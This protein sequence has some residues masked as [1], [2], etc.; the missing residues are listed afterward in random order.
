MTASE[1]IVPAPG[2]IP[3][4]DE[5]DP[6]RYVMNMDWVWSRKHNR[7]L[8]KRATVRATVTAP[9]MG[10]LRNTFYEWAAHLRDPG[11]DAVYVS[12]GWFCQLERSDSAG[13]ALLF[14]SRGQDVAE[15]LDFGIQWFSGAVLGAIPSAEVSWQELPLD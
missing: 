6:R 10:K 2:I 7:E 1:E 12:G 14:G 15:S 11:D 9:D 5:S 13:L 4:L 3:E 8:N